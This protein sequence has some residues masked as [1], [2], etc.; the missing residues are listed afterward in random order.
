[1]RRH[2]ERALDLAAAVA[3]GFALPAAASPPCRSTSPAPLVRARDTLDGAQPAGEA[4]AVE[5]LA[6]AAAWTDRDDWRAAAEAA[7]AG[8]EA[9][10]RVAPDG[11]RLGPAGGAAPARPAPQV[12][13]VGRADDPRTIALLAAAALPGADLRRAQRRRRRPL[14][15][16]L[17][18]LA[19]RDAVGGRPTAYACA[20]GVC[21]LPVHDVPT[22]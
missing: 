9:T 15:E 12:V 20:A 19:G 3:D 16:R 18:W 21:R 14:V 4:A 1:V 6:W 11:G 8:A 17:P 13:V 7:L 10:A 2:L 22:R 5:L